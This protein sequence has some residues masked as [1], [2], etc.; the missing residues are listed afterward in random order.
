MLS[1]SSVKS[2]LDHQVWKLVKQNSLQNQRIL[3]ALS[4]GIDSVALLRV[5]SKITPT[6]MIAAAY[7][8]HGMDSNQEYRERAQLF[9]EG[10]CAKLGVRFF[11]LHAPIQA[12]SEAG[13]R[14]MRYQS[15]RELMAR[16]GFA[17]LAT[18]HHCEDLLETRLLRLLRGTG[19]QGLEAMQELKEDIFRPLL[20]VSKKDLRHYIESEG[21]LFCE[22]PS[23]KS[24][25]PLRNW[26]RE[27]WLPA[28]ERRAPG[29]VAV[30]ARS[31][32]TIVEE[33]QDRAW[34]DLLAF[35]AEYRSQGLS[36][37]FYLTLS[38]SEQKR[39]IA[40]YLYALGKKDF[41]QSHLQEIQKRLD[42]SQKVITF[43]VCGCNW[44]IN[45]EQ[46][47]VQS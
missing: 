19:A 16:E 5:L 35:N 20:R 47:K 42:N 33:L 46:I 2:D 13:Y 45:A 32:E 31:L 37:S 11:V 15:L 1:V 4:G 27:D 30:M 24:L 10:L 44:E 26:L 12:T 25:D 6:G 41:S 8:H 36:R 29:S 18:G 22:D 23:N 34:G 9:C 21:L 14:E 43:T 40:Q 38:L 28:L 7:F 39:L 17:K 3:V